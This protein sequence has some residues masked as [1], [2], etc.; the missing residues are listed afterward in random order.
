MLFGQE[1][2][3]GHVV[4][5]KERLKELDR[6]RGIYEGEAYQ[7]KQ[8]PYL[9]SN[10]SHTDAVK[11]HFDEM[12]GE[13]LFF[14]V[15]PS[16][17]GRIV[18]EHS[19]TKT[20]IKKHIKSKLMATKKAAKKAA[21]KKKATAKKEGVTIK[22]FVEGLVSKGKTNAEI[23]EALNKAGMVYSEA[24]VRWYASKARA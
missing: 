21:P 18:V 12:D 19:Q 15:K 10:G 13:L 20:H 1:V 9:P 24:S 5:A 11:A 22:S 16:T 8:L 14:E 3:A 23:F 17:S 4:R 7:K 2:D 6:L